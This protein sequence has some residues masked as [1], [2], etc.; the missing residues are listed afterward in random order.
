LS[1]DNRDDANNPG[2]G[3]LWLGLVAAVVLSTVIFVGVWIAA[4]DD[5][6]QADGAADSAQSSVPSD[7]GDAASGSSTGS[8]DTPDEGED[9]IG[10]FI[11]DSGDHTLLANAI[12][13]TGLSDEL[14]GE[15]PFTVFAPTDSDID[16]TVAAATLTNP[17]ADIERTLQFH[18]VDGTLSA[19]DLASVRSVTTLSGDELRIFTLAGGDGLLIHNGVSVGE[20]TEFDNGILYSV[21]SLLVPT[22]AAAPS[23]ST[24]TTTTTVAE[25]DETTST[26]ADD[27]ATSSTTTTAS[28]TGELADLSDLD[29]IQF[30]DSSA[31]IDGGSLATLDLVV[32]IL[33]ANPT[34]NIE[35]GGHTD[36]I[37]PVGG[38]IRLSE[39]RANAVRDYLISRGIDA[40]RLTAVGYGPDQPIASNDTAEGRAENRRIE[41]TVT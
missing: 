15:G 16:P 8:D 26:V 27:V 39:R 38:N 18:I 12:E 9:T 4:G 13:A 19:D 6:E 30:A 35:I 3:V 23:T 5:E 36:N 25:S 20:S 10:E 31:V 14:D 22:G 11:A 41:F 34:A 33:N 37:G 24:S 29:P 2:R 7:D 1:I 32:D 21:S 40:S 17:D 28:G